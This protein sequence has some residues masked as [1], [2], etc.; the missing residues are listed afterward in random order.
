MAR[1]EPVPIPLNWADHSVRVPTTR[2][3]ANG[4]LVLGVRP[5]HVRFSDQ[6]DYRGEVVATEYLG[7]TQ[8]VTLSTP[9]GQ[10]KARTAASVPVANGEMIGLEFDSRTLTIFDGDSGDA[11]LSESNEGVLNH[12]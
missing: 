7:T 6:S 11:L 10:I 9:N 4:N 5:E 8:I 3:G 1:S 2:T 12:G